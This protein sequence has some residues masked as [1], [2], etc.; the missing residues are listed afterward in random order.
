MADSTI[1]SQQFALFDFWP[2]VARHVS[3]DNMPAAFTTPVATAVFGPG[4]KICAWNEGGTAG[5]DGYATFIYLQVGTQNTDVAIAVKTF[6]VPG[7]ATTP[8]VVGNNPDTDIILHTGSPFV[9]VALSAVTNAYWAWFWCG[10]VCPEA[11]VSTLGGTYV[12]D[13]SVAIGP[14]SITNCA[15]DFMGLGVTGADTE[16]VI[17]MALAADAA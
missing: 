4:E 7:S 17:G 10:G 6:C 16:A 9:G 1:D 14:M 12:T 5:I 11:I 13:N 3:P 2:G 15:G 8:F